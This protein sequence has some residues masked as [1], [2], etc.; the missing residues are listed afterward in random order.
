[1][2][3]YIK[4]FNANKLKI[5]KKKKHSSLENRSSLFPVDAC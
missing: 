1:M 4:L 3:I 2:I 5:M